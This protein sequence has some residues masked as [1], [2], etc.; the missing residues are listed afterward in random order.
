M[1][2]ES[3][4]EG[5][6]SN[7]G[8]EDSISAGD[9]LLQE[10]L[11]RG[12]TEKQVADKLH[13][14]MHYV[15]ALET[16][17]YEKLP[18]A[19]FAKGY[20]KSY[21]LL[22][23]L[24]AD[25]LLSRYDEFNTQRQAGIAEASRLK[26]R[27]KKNRNKP[28][29]IM[30]LLVFIAGFIGLWLANSYFGE[31]STTESPAN[32]GTDAD[33]ADSLRP[34]LGREV[35]A[36]ATEAQ[37]SLHS[38]PDETIESVDEPIASTAASIESVQTPIDGIAAEV[39]ATSQSGTEFNNSRESETSALDET[40]ILLSNSQNEFA[41]TA[42]TEYESP[43]ASAEMSQVI[44]VGVAGSDVLRISFS[45]ESWVEVNDSDAQQIYRDIRVAGDVLEIT[46]SA[47]F[48]I[49]LGDAPFTRMS[50]NGNEIDLS[51][52]IRIDNSARLTVGL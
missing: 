10:R 6:P 2:T 51:G 28:F 48:S 12:L 36:A 26:A 37:L 25:D 11:R 45:G 44:E 17:Q 4:A 1:P 47:P 13:I 43:V 8:A 30:S 5:I 22:L 32:V 41:N 21:A 38:E 9:V 35:E 42:E 34:A 24:E 46:G 31:G 3:H 40:A 23:G 15:K 14:T 39:P 29:V 19:V 33:D 7:D 16:N 20:I 50:L 18:G 49:L 27:R 52:N